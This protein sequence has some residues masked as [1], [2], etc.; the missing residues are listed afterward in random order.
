M[1][2]LRK[3]SDDGVYFGPVGM[4]D[5]NRFGGQRAGLGEE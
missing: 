2:F 3:G 4:E 5:K 1:E